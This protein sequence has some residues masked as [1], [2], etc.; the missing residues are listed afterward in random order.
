MSARIYWIG[1]DFDELRTYWYN[2]TE[3]DED[4]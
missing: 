1:V 2:K 4:E 3:E